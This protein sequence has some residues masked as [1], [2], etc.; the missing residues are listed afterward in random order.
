MFKSYVEPFACSIGKEEFNLLCLFVEECVGQF[1]TSFLP[2]DDIVFKQGD[3]G[4]RR[5]V[6]ERKQVHKESDRCLCALWGEAKNGCV[7][8]LCVSLI[9]GEPVGTYPQTLDLLKLPTDSRSFSR[10]H[11]RAMASRV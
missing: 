4:I 1:P 3:A 11:W 6:G 10:L 2:V 9:V 5:I 8:H 7:A